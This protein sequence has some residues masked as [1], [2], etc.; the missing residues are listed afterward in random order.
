MITKQQV[1]GLIERLADKTLSFG[2]MIDD[3]NHFPST[4]MFVSHGIGQIYSGIQ[5]GGG[6]TY[7]FFNGYMNPETEILGHP[8]TIGNVLE[9]IQGIAKKEYC[10]HCDM[11]GTDGKTLKLLMLW[12]PL[13]LSRSLQEIIEDSEWKTKVVC[14][15]CGDECS[16]ECYGGQNIEITHLTSP[17]ANSLFE[18][19]LHLF[20]EKNEYKN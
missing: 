2:C 11:C 13:G 3:K 1:E 8:I 14:Q 19:L 7:N 5:F 18:F 10:E 15:S 12:Q 4:I 20:P 16:Y 6:N 17:E 9:K